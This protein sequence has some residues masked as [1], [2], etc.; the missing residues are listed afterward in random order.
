MARLFW[1]SPD[2]SPIIA[3]DRRP[4]SEQIETITGKTVVN[5]HIQTEQDLAAKSLKEFSVDVIAHFEDG[6]WLS[7]FLSF[8]SDA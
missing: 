8:H 1:H 2:Y 6:T 7:L 4:M 5:I 3:L